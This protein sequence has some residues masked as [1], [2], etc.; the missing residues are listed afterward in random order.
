MKILDIGCGLRKIPGALTID[1]DINVKPDILWDLNVYPYPLEDNTFDIIYANDIIEHLIEPDNMIKEIWRIGIPGA[2]VNINTVFASGRNCYH[3]LQHKRG[4]IS[5]SFER[6]IDGAV[7]MSTKEK[8]KL[9]GCEYEPGIYRQ[10]WWDRS[11]I[12]LANENKE[13][14]EARFMWIYPLETISYKLEIIK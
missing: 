5:T 10:H 2:E 11:L 8:F 9:L 14:Y 6:Y 4:F 3:E 1:K 7:A 12:Q 13:Y